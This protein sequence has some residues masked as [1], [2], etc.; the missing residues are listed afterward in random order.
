MPA[1]LATYCAGQQ[2]PKLFWELHDWI[3]ENQDKWSEATDG[4]D[5]FKK[6]ALALGVKEADYDKC[7]QDPASIARIQK[8][9]QDGLARGIQGTP[10]FFVNDW[11][12]NGAVGIDEFKDKI[13]KAKAGEKPAPTPT[14][15]P[16]PTPMPEGVEFW[17]PD[18]QLPGRNYDGSF[19]LGDAEAPVFV[20]AFEDFKSPESAEHVKSVEPKLKSDYIDKGALRY[21]VSP[22]AVNAPRAAVAALC[23][24]Q[25]NKFWEFRNLLLTKQNEWQEGDDAAMQGYAK[26]LGLDE[27]AFAQ[28]LKD[29]KVQTQVYQYLSFGQNEI[30]VP[31]APS[32]LMFRLNAE[33]QVENVKGYPGALPLDQFEQAVKELSTPPTPTPTPAPSI[34]KADL[35]NLP[36][37]RDADGN[38][39]RG[40]PNAAVKLVDYSDFQ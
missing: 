33:G 34:S 19:Y 9:M 11:F 37:G 24:G 15:L 16:T 35:T 17:Q 10:A 40:D 8:D 31:T 25:Q 39:Y 1:S 3:F 28:C 14:P 26:S 13:E 12:I 7:I 29:E 32:Y 36:V 5:Q 6:Q 23:A 21:I 30:Q 2:E 22:Y 20:L 27:A 18:P 4:A 38:F